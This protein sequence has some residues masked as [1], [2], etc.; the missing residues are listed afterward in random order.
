[1]VPQD[2]WLAVSYTAEVQNEATV[3]MGLCN[4]LIFCGSVYADVN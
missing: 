3:E 2:G 1:M 4:R